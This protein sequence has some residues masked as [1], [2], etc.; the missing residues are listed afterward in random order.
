MA[1]DERDQTVKAEDETFAAIFVRASEG[2]QSRARQ[3]SYGLPVALGETLV[4]GRLKLC[5]RIGAGGMG[6][7]YEVYDERRRGNVALKTLSRLDSGG[8][9]RLKNEFRSLAGVSHPNLCRL[10]ELFSDRGQWFF[11]MELVEGVPFDLWVRPND[12]V[13][14]GRLREALAQ[15]IDGICAIH[16]AGKLHRDLKPSNVLVAPDGRVVVLDF[17]LAVDPDFGGVGQTLLELSVSGTPA[18]MAPEQ[19]AGAAASTA[20]DFYALGVMLFEVLTGELPFGGRAGEMLASKQLKRAPAPSS[21]SSG[22][23]SDLVALCEGL[24]AREQAERPGAD[25]LIAKLGHGSQHARRSASSRTGASA[26]RTHGAGTA[27]PASQTMLL[28]RD[29]E[30]A[31]LREAYAAMS[32]ET[33]VVMFISGE[34]GMGK[35]TLISA[36]L[37]ELRSA[38]QAV[39]LA[40][41]CYERENVPFK[42]FDALV[43]DLSRHLRR[44]SREHATAVLPREVFALAR[45]F[46]VLG[47]VPVVAEAPAKAIDDPQDLRRRA[48]EAFGEMLRRMRDR[49]P[50]CIHID[51]LQWADLD[52]VHFMRALLVDR[53]PAPA[54]FLLSHRS[55]GAAQN[56][57]LSEIVEVAQ[58]NSILRVN[59]L[60]VGPLSTDAALSLAQRSLPPDVLDR[61]ALSRVIAREA[62]GSPFFVAELAGYA[63]RS[64]GELTG[65]SLSAVLTAHLAALSAPARALLEVTA[66]AGQPL[67]AELLLGA[68]S[69]SH[70]ALD[71][72]RAMRLV[73][74]GGA[75]KGSTLECYHDRIRETVAHGLDDGARSRCYRALADGLLVQP[76]ADPELLATCLECS[77]QAALAAHYAALAAARAELGMA[78]DRA[79]SLYRKALA[80]APA[81]DPEQHTRSVALAEA[82]ANA[83]RGREAADAFLLAA[84]RKHGPDRI[85]LRR[86]AADQL[87]TCGYVAEGKAALA[88]VCADVGVPLPRDGRAAL[89]SLAFTQARIRMQSEL[90]PQRLRP[91]ALSALERVRLEVAWSATNSLVA[92]DAV[93][94]AA[95]CDRHYLLAREAADPYHLALALN[96]RAFYATAFAPHDEARIAELYALA[97]RFAA[98]L[99]RADLAGRIAL[100]QGS[101]REYGRSIDV[102]TARERLLRSRELLRGCRGVRYE[103]D[104]TNV[105]LVMDPSEDLAHEARIAA[106]LAEE[107]FSLGR[108]WCAAMVVG[109]SSL[110]RLAAGDLAGLLRHFGRAEREWQAVPELQWVDISL[111]YAAADLGHYRGEPE[112]ALA[113]AE[114][115]WLRYEHSPLRRARAARARLHGLRGLLALSTARRPAGAQRRREL[116]ALAAA[117]SGAIER[118]SSTKHST[119]AC[120]LKL[121]LALAQNDRREAERL[122]RAFLEAASPQLTSGL[123]RP[124]AHRRLGQLL[125]GDQGAALIGAAEADLRAR[126]VADL[127]RVCELV[128]PGCRLG[129]V[130][131]LTSPVGKAC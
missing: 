65:L 33:A 41:R 93:T 60:L 107:A 130:P 73:R 120:K 85:D 131:R 75:E 125:G 13:D 21:L 17:G 18:Y 71:E 40:G 12:S 88:Q 106:Q 112:P 34:S 1:A 68:A 61:D 59:S 89:L 8:V 31:A 56:E 103:V 92:H 90:D 38:N 44:L 19:A 77:G 114:A 53:E 58:A 97:E 14:E 32:G 109:H 43:D 118:L 86:R 84:A 25:A 29:A 30:L 24:L 115:L 116:L 35:S 91:K 7:V 28:G 6:V 63:L 111:L 119:M 101:G 121:G 70:D 129:A 49:K 80:L 122:L 127:E 117:D 16:A 102:K 51:D 74:A 66:V 79:A 11:T 62:G 124:C 37:D 87:L 27:P 47:R 57:L 26:V 15:L 82:L 110:Q 55:E 20:S 5:R 39:V 126:G 23:P 54:L 3:S 45:V 96:Y 95:M 72:L 76:G 94:A 83:G 113:A 123:A 67:P 10:H 81:G 52:S 78:F 99:A 98:P 100:H 108:V 128:L 69:A 64:G 42:G 4:D 50:L 48:F 22:L 2:W 46:P 105:F 104:A 9:Y 36:F